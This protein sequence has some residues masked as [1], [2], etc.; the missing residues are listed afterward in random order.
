MLLAKEKFLEL[1]NSYPESFY[2]E[3]AHYRYIAILGFEKNKKF[4][5]KKKN[6]FLSSIVIVSFQV[7]LESDNLLKKDP[8]IPED[9]KLFK[10]AKK[11]VAAKNLKRL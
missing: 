11:L 9:E 8:V 2:G 5:K 4:T 3:Q 10:E 6:K 7:L 1:K